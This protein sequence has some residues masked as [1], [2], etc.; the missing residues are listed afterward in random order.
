MIVSVNLLYFWMGRVVEFRVYITKPHSMYTFIV[1]L[2]L[3]PPIPS[4]ILNVSRYTPTKI[5]VKQ[6]FN[7]VIYK[8]KIRRFINTLQNNSRLNCTLFFLFPNFLYIWVC[9]WKDC[10]RKQTQQLCLLCTNKVS[11]VSQCGYTYFVCR[12]YSFIQR[13]HTPF[14]FSIF[15]HSWNEKQQLLFCLLFRLVFNVCL[16]SWYR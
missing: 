3:F 4:F 7:T 12:D 9:N 15:R 5:Q 11:R 1:S 8:L 16:V 13:R 6:I 10:R 14:S 2:H